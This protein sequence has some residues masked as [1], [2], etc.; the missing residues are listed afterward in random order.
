MKKG[1]LINSEISYG[2]SKLGHKDSIVIGDAGLPVPHGVQ[3]VDLAVS[4]GIPS[5]L[6]VLSAVLSE[7]KIEKIILA[8]EI[9]TASTT[10]H[11][12]ILSVCKG[13]EGNLE[14]EYVPHEEFKRNT[15]KC[16]FAVRT[17]EFTPFANIILISGVVF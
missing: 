13:A 1:L 6:S 11:E 5:F 7:Q 17:G 16:K 15:G 4:K 14:I 3:R 2:I 10:L 12:Q 8:E 9:K